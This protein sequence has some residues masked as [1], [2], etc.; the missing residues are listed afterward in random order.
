MIYSIRFS[1]DE[2]AAIE[3]YALLYGIKISEVIR[4]ATM[5]IIEDEMDPQT[6][7]DTRERFEK[8]PLLV[9]MKT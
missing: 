9:P 3:Q 8:N 1:E 5:E 2:Q 6:F 4:K 7:K